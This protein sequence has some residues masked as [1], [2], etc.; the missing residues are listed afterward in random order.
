MSSVVA[1]VVLVF[2]CLRDI[3]RR[4][5]GIAAYILIFQENHLIP[6][7]N[8]GVEWAGYIFYLFIVILVVLRWG[9][10]LRI[11]TVTI[12]VFNSLYFKIIFSI[13]FLLVIHTLVGSVGTQSSSILVVR[14]FTQLL[15]VICFMIFWIG[16]EANSSV[17]DEIAR[18]ILRYGLLLAMILVI[19]GNVFQVS[20]LVRKDIADTVG[21]SPIAV[22]RTGCTMFISSLYLLSKSGRYGLQSVAMIIGIILIVLGMSRGPLFA[23][24]IVSSGW[25]YIR[26]RDLL[27]IV[28]RRPFLF[29]I[30]ISLISLLLA[31]L[32]S[33]S[34]GSRYIER[35][36]G[37]GSLDDTYRFQRW[38][39]AIEYFTNDFDILSFK[40][41][42]GVGPAG[43]DATYGLNYAHN[44]FLEFAFEYGLIGLI[45]VSLIAIMLGVNF[46]RYCS[47]YKKHEYLA[48]TALYLFICANFSGDIIGWRNML[49]VTCLMIISNKTFKYEHSS[50][51]Y[52][53]MWNY[54][55]G[56]I[57]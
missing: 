11:S 16:G 24:I 50:R 39:F 35:I 36:Q 30:S 32:F 1:I 48:L 13:S 5:I 45:L 52:R 22:T 28:N 15:P 46:R 2:L 43:F 12:A 55:P 51:Q 7:G 17:F 9:V 21:M 33:S 56:E 44:I 49:F 19:S 27:D 20:N 37:L 54:S 4:D 23:T 53:K 3:Y 41:L 14:Y 26:R 57:I 38:I 18:G 42:F 40:G 34:I 29:A 25:A 31:I 47:S 10:F 6:F 8:L